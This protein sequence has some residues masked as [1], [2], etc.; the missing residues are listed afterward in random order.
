[1]LLK[2]SLKS[3]ESAHKSQCVNS[4]KPKSSRKL[5]NSPYNSPTVSRKHKQ[6]DSRKSKLI[7]DIAHLEEYRPYDRYEEEYKRPMFE[8]SNMAGDIETANITKNQFEDAV[9]SVQSQDVNF[10]TYKEETDEMIN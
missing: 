7:G 1:M 5:S 9:R 3:R 6:S 8:Y 2:I 10:D 4:P